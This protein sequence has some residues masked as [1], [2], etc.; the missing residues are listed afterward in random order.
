ISNNQRSILKEFVLRVYLKNSSL[1]GI[2]L[3][4]T[5]KAARRQLLFMKSYLKFR[6]LIYH[7]YVTLRTQRRG[8]I[9][10]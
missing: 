3:A 8:I 9:S 2:K 7:L 4:S 5:K 10:P 6:P 1:Y